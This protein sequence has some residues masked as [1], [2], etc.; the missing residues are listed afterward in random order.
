[1]L[2]NATRAT[3]PRL[4]LLHFGSTTLSLT[5]TRSFDA[6][7]LLSLASLASVADAVL[8]MRVVDHP[9]PFCQ[10]YAVGL[11]ELKSADP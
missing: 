8:R 6:A 3:T 5:A 4:L 7:R 2:S 10:H 1:L 9:S 11:Y